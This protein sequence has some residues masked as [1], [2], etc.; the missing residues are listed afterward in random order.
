[1]G[2]KAELGK[3]GYSR[4]HRPDKKQIMIG[5]S[6]LRTPI[7]IP[8][9]LTIQSG[10]MND[11]THFQK[12]FLQI[13]PKLKEGSLAVFDK[14]AQSKENIELVLAH[15]MK[16]LS[17]KKLN[18]SDDKRIKVFEKT[19]DKCINKELGIYGEII[20]FPSRYD[21]F[22]YSEPLMHDQI[23]AKLRLAETKLIEAKEIQKAIAKGNPLPKR[24]ILNN[25]LIDIKY[26]YQTKLTE[27]NDEQAK[28]WFKRQLSQAE[29]VFLPSFK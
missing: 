6:Q 12:T 22:F 28:N 17:S 18:A 1:M 7:N 29:K 10:N 16:Y 23:A 20:E 19:D 11:Q 8:I 24:F 3:Y 27:L 2:T 9:G 4:A 13:A 26:S 5:L 15:K 14:G 21:Y 25:P